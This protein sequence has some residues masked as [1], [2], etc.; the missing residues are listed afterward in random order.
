MVRRPQTGYW[1][2]IDNI[3]VNCPKDDYESTTTVHIPYD[4][5]LALNDA[6]RAKE[7]VL[8]YAGAGSPSLQ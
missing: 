1:E 5:S 7:L 8:Q 6:E 3:F 2:V 4:Y